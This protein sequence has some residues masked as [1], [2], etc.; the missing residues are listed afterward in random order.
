MA[1]KKNRAGEGGRR[2][3]L[4]VKLRLF[5]LLVC[6]LP[7]CKQGFLLPFSK[8]HYFPHGLLLFWL[9]TLHDLLLSSYNGTVSTGQP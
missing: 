4:R 6:N 8:P 2:E 7:L 3:H 9:S 1:G 5:K